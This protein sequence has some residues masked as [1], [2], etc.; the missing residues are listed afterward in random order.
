MTNHGFDWDYFA[1]SS[2][3]YLR[4]GVARFRLSREFHRGK[5]RIKLYFLWL[6]KILKPISTSCH[7]KNSILRECMAC[8]EIFF[9]PEK[10]GKMKKVLVACPAAVKGFCGICAFSFFVSCSHFRKNYCVRDPTWFGETHRAGS[11]RLFIDKSENLFLKLISAKN[12]EKRP[13]Q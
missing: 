5:F 7:R 2:I 4:I 3:L 8:V 6:E 12:E 11:S 9:I 13:C 1:F 10:V